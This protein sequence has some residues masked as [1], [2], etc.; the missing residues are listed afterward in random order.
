M[1][2]WTI[3]LIPLL[4]PGVAGVALALNPFGGHV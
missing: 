3:M 4:L 1:W 2:V